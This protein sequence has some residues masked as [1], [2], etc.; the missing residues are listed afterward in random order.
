MKRIFTLCL[1]LCLISSAS[2][3]VRRYLYCATPDGAQA[4]GKSGTGIVIFDID[5]ISIQHLET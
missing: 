2:A 5:I 1:A 3:E 4:Q